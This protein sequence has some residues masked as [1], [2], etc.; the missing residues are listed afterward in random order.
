MVNTGV[1]SDAAGKITVSM[2][3]SVKGNDEQLKISLTKLDPNAT[4]ELV[5][6]IG[7]DT[8]AMNIAALTTDR[9]GAFN[10][11]YVEKGQG[12]SSSHADVL[13][14]LL[15]PLCNVRRLMIVNSSTQREIRAVGLR[16]IDRSSL[17]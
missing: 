16:S 7:D 14:T 10:V 9:K 15:D 4:Y 17:T 11:S 6:F 8:N 2:K 3:G 12:N 13:P 1:D 5:A